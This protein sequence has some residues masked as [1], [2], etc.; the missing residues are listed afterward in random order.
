[1]SRSRKEAGVVCSPS[2]PL[3]SVL[4]VL[5]TLSALL[6]SAPVMSGPLTS[7]PL[8]SKEAT[9]EDAMTGI[10]IAKMTRPDHEK[11]FAQCRV[12]LSRPPQSVGEWMQVRAQMQP[13]RT[14]CDDDAAFLAL[15]GAAQLNTGALDEA[16]QS[17]EHALM[18]DPMQGGARVDYAE[19]LYLDGQPFAAL[20]LNHDLLKADNIPS[21]LAIRLEERQKHWKEA[22]SQWH[23]QLALSFGRDT[24]LNSAPHDDVIRL[25]LSNVDLALTLSGDD[26]PKAGNVVQMAWSSLYE[27]QLPEGQ[28]YFRLNLNSRNT[29]DSDYNAHQGS[30]TIGRRFDA[31]RSQWDLSL[32][33]Q[34]LQYGGELLYT[35]LEGEV[36]W[37]HGVHLMGCQPGVDFSYEYQRFPGSRS[38][39]G[40]EAQL[41][42]SLNCRWGYVSSQLSAG[43]L[44]N[45][46]IHRDRVGGDRIGWQ[47]Q[48]Q[49]GFP[50]ASGRMSASVGWTQLRDR[51]GYSALLND[52][53]ARHIRQYNYGLQYVYPISNAQAITLGGQ[54]R[55]QH[56]N[57]QLFEHQNTQ[58]EVG[59]LWIF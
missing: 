51:E 13:R 9:A 4:F 22:L 41:G 16:L 19:A 50:L 33:G 55:I 27:K 46:G 59:I 20:A 15:L 18:L 30:V 53:A 11:I 38:L 3:S 12:V 2:H 32:T 42:P 23:H 48:W 21:A 43:G 24:N 6:L 10:M 47:A 8:T 44:I 54:R 39:D 25:T 58:Y 45:N 52:G 7:E 56:S 28:Q 36:Q 34:A 40:Q 26:R 31:R 14:L 17:L 49:V 5:M 57:L 37:Q 1:M 29:P 35:S